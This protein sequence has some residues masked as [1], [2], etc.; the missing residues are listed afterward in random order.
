MANAINAIK[1]IISDRIWF[2]KIAVLAI[3]VYLYFTVDN[4]ASS[5]LVNDLNFWAALSILYLGVSSVLIHRNVNNKVPILP[6]LFDVI[7]IIRRSICSFIVALPGLISLFVVLYL[8]NT[9]L[10]YLSDTVKII[11]HAACIVILFPFISIP[12]VIYSAN[13]KLTDLFKVKNVQSASGD[14]IVS[15]ITFL[16]QYALT[17]A[18]F[19]F[20]VYEA[21]KTFYG[22]NFM[23]IPILFSF[24]ITFSYIMLFSWASDLYGQIIPA[25]ENKPKKDKALR[26]TF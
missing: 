24:V 6:S 12:V 26:E 2:I 16:I 9:Y 18:F 13:G 23:G 20:L 11:A 4:F 1:N 8:L 21:F 25:V 22:E 7:D 17:V 14:F 15:F 5:I 10:P 3:P 19:T